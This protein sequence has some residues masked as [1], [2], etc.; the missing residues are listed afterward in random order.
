MA[1]VQSVS[2]YG[3]IGGGKMA[4]R[5]AGIFSGFIDKAGKKYD[6]SQLPDKVKRAIV[7]MFIKAD[8]KR[9]QQL[10][11]ENAQEMAESN[12]HM[13]GSSNKNL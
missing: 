2:A 4:R 12:W 13:R 5:C 11:L 6:S 7:T 8:I 9:R 1:S 10:S 3:L